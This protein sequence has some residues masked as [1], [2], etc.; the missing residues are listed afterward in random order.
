VR[1][2]AAG[3]FGNKGEDMSERMADMLDR[4]GDGTAGDALREGLRTLGRG[5][6]ATPFQLDRRVNDLLGRLPDPGKF[7][8]EGENNLWS[9]IRSAFRGSRLPSVP[10]LGGRGEVTG[11]GEDVGLLPLA[12][13]LGVVVVV[14]YLL[15]RSPGRRPGGAEAPWK[16]GPWPVAPGAVATRHDLVRAFEHLALLCFGPGALHCHHLELARRLEDEANDDRCRQ[17]ARELGRLYEHARYAPD[18]DPL[19]A[20]ELVAAR[21]DLSLLAGVAAS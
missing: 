1:E 16:L 2:R 8:P 6:S 11:P 20:E 12:A 9:D 10:K 18:G 14:G 5:D 7:F 21:A 17:A 19:A 15:W 13:W 4:V 3:W